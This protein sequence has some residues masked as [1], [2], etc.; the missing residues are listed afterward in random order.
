MV[1]QLGSFTA[2]FLKPQRSRFLLAG[3]LLVLTSLIGCGTSEHVIQTAPPSEEYIAPEY[4]IGVGDL[5]SVN[6]WKNEDVSGD[7]LVRPMHW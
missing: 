4:R 5:L 7:A 1:E 6:V 3:L 2:K